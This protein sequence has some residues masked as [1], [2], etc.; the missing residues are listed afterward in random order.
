MTTSKTAKLPLVYATA[1]NE[2]YHN[3]GENAESGSV[4]QLCFGGLFACSR[5]S[6]WIFMGC[7]LE[8]P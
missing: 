3:N 8:K 5:K 6:L 4:I 2:H 1:S 7:V